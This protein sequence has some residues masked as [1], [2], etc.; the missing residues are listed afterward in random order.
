MAREGLGIAVT[1][2]RPPHPIQYE[3]GGGAEWGRQTGSG[4]SPP[5]LGS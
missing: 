5:V 4:P 2:S 3:E 1:P